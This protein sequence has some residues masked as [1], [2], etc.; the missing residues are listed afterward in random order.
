MQNEKKF[1]FN[2]L[3]GFILI[4][5][6][7][8]GYY[9]MTKPTEEELAQAKKELALKEQQQA[10]ATQ[11]QQ[12]NNTANATID[13]AQIVTEVKNISLENDKVKID[14]NGLGGQ[15]GL[16]EIKN[17]LAYDS[18]KGKDAQPLYLVKD[19]NNR[20]NLSF[21]DKQ[22]RII[23]TADLPF[24][25][26]VQQ[27]GNAS[28]VTM[29]AK[30][31]GGEINYIYTFDNTYGV[32]FQVNTRGL[33][34]MTSDQQVALDWSLN[35]FSLEKGKD[36]EHY[37][38]HTY[39]RLKDDKDVEYELFGADKWTEKESI[40]WIAFKQQFFASILSFDEGLKNTSA[41]SENIP[42]D[43][44]KYNKAFKFNANLDLKAGELNHQFTWDFVPL[45][46]KELK[47]YN[48]K[49]FQNIVSYGWGI[50]G[51]LNKFFFLNIFQWLANLGLK[52]GWV[53]FLMTIVVK[54]V[55]SPIMYKQYRQSAMMK[56][57]RPELNELNEK[58]KD[59]KD[60]MKKQQE[61]M[62][63]YRKAGVNPLAGCLPALLQ[64]PI[65]YALF[66]FFPNVIDLRG[67]PFWFA[68]DLTAFDSV[69]QIPDWI[70]FLNGHLSI[71][72]M[73]YIVAMMVYFKVSGSMDNFGN[74]PQ[75][76][77]MPNMQFMK[78]M[79]YVMPIFF[80]V[81]LN[82]Y[83]SG[84]SW[85]YLVSNVINI[86]IILYIKNVM[87]NEEKIHAIIQ[88]NKT[89]PKKESKFSQRMQEMMKKAQEMQAEQERMK[90]QNKK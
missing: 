63:I 80:F 4:G 29:T 5:V 2:Q 65:F 52:Y 41:S 21:K 46:Y 11:A 85:Y 7:F 90:R 12:P 1:D 55:L 3:I 9:W 67:K 68:E 23:N 32:N 81:F 15:I 71:F 45:D 88:E 42:V 56:V 49:D 33:S 17:H 44:P 22:G 70:P 24:S 28:I 30:I 53:I 18:T 20:F 82:N 76:E 73:L 64:I 79:M 59:P 69:I 36:Q 6:L 10:T 84:L 19:G 61:T 51:W 57:L 78:Y 34:T 26:S 54:L 27:N 62:A 40:D 86:F 89:K 38:S 37:W 25:S 50:I 35:G 39:Y 31:N 83:A 48:D 47:T 72:A 77:G 75:Q 43:D 66:R 87:I 60:A 74:M 16:V 14:L 8:L 58:Y 13:S